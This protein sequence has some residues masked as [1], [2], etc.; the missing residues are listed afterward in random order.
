MGTSAQ[1]RPAPG[2]VQPTAPPWSVLALLPRPFWPW[3][4]NYFAYA[5]SEL[6]LAASETATLSTQISTD[7]WFVMLACT[8]VML[9][10]NNTTLIASRPCT[11]QIYDTS[12]GM[13]LFSQAIHAD[14]FFVAQSGRTILPRPQSGRGPPRKFYQRERTDRRDLGL[15]RRA[16]PAPDALR[17]EGQR[18]KHSGEDSARPRG[19]GTGFDRS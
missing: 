4:K 16:K 2:Y 1:P 11:V 3:L 8:M 14:E 7:A 12:A 18:P 13:N 10:T 9:D 15:S 6:P 19:R 17:M 5:A